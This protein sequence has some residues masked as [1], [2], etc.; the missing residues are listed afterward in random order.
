MN[1]ASS[2]S[3]TLAER[4][5]VI[6]FGSCV[7]GQF[8]IDTVL[9]VADRRENHNA[10]NF[11]RLK[12][13]VPRAYWEVTLRALYYSDESSGCRERCTGDSYRL[14]WGASFDNRVDGMFSFFPCMLAHQKL[15]SRESSEM[16]SA[17][18]TD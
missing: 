3:F 14:Y 17:G 4:G 13:L 16:T 5:S 10:G 2:N 9:V 6:L 12:N 7:G 15:Q 11:Q 18:A 1:Y 8:A